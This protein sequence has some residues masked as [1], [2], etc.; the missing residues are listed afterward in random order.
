M[1]HWTITA[2]LL[3][4]VHR[5]ETP[6]LPAIHWTKPTLL[7]A[8]HWTETALLPA[9][10]RAK[11]TL[12]S[13]IHRA[14]TALLA[15]VHWTKPTLLSSIHRTIT[16][17]LAAVH[18]TKATLLSTIHWTITALLL[19]AIHRTITPLLLAMV[20]RPKSPLLA[21]IRWAISLGA[22]FVLRS[23]VS[24]IF[25]L[26]AGNLLPL[27]I[28]IESS[29]ATALRLVLIAVLLIAVALVELFLH[30]IELCREFLDLSF[31]PHDGLL[32]DALALIPCALSPIHRAKA[33]APIEPRTGTK[34][35]AKAI[36]VAIA[37]S[38]LPIDIR[39]VLPPGTTGIAG[40]TFPRRRSRGRGWVGMR[41]DGCGEQTKNAGKNGE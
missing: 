2:L 9:V 16:A 3:A 15:T 11:A 12:L 18:W 4:A 14:I 34:A 39:L 19:G 36:A 25:I 13:A 5:S 37:W 40:G 8:I 10:H 1:I 30:P 28:A 32:I 41:A 31:E 21:P 24:S 38:P 35:P 6:L 17:L 26:L 20:H 23:V 7:S 27:R 22:I 33:A 29:L